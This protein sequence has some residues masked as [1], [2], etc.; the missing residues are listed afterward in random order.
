MCMKKND[1]GLECSEAGEAMGDGAT[2]KVKVRAVD[3][4]TA[5]GDSVALSAAGAVAAEAAPL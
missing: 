1:V 2:Q 4:P 5:V 3:A